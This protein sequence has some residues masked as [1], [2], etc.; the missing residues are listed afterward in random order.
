MGL[1]EKLTSEFV[2]IIEWLDQSN[3]TIAYR[4]ERFQNEI[5]MGAKL[6][7]RPGQKAV[8]VNEGQVADAFDPGMYTLSTQN[9]PILSTLKGFPYGFNSPFKAEVY[10]FNTKIFTNLKW[11]TSNPIAI[12]VPDLGGTVRI[13]AYGTYSMRVQDPVRLLEDLVSTDGLFQI[14]EIS[15]QIRNMLVSSFATW[16]G[17]SGLN[18]ADFAA[19]YRASGDTIRNAIQADIEEFGITLPHFLIENISLPPEVEKALDRRASINVLGNMQEYTQYQAANA[20]E[21]SAENPNGGNQAVEL[22][23]GLAMGQQIVNAMQGNMATAQPAPAQPPAV[24]VGAPP[25]PMTQT[26]WY[27]TRD[28]QNFGPFATNQLLANGLTPQSYVWRNG[29]SGWQQAATLPEL[30]SLFPA[31][32]PP[33]MAQ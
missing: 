21:A 11:G 19:N 7:V 29:I 25:P 28:G 8:F 10:F 26:Q 6:T 9:M 16:L 17:Q 3:D 32:P 30:A 23:V 24:A 33:P 15:D 1:F 2:D 14:D 4:F 20:I 18:F 12:N 27:I 5:K 31:S 22:G 13:R